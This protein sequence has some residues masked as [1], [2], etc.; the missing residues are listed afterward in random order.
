M[1]KNLIALY[2]LVLCF[3][4]WIVAEVLGLLETSCIVTRG[5]YG[6]IERKVATLSDEL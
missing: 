5:L 6:R 1:R 4:W 3:V 2:A